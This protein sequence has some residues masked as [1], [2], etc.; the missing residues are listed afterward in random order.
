MAESD[1]NQTQALLTSEPVQ[2]EEKSPADNAV[3]SVQPFA[4]VDQLPVFSTKV[5][6]HSYLA[7]S[8]IVAVLCGICNLSSITC[9]IPAIALSVLVSRKYI[10]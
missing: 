9:T 10:V 8:V 1:A 3:S 6:P 5:Y 7:C 4:S 2:L